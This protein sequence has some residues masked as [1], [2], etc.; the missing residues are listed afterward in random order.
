[1][2]YGFFLVLERAGLGKLL[3]HLW[4]P[5]RH[6]YTMVIVFI[7]WVFF[8][9]ETLSYS[10]QFIKA[11]FGFG[12][13]SGVEYYASS[14]LSFEVLLVVAIGAIGSMPIIPRLIKLKNSNI[15]L[16][17]VMNIFQDSYLFCV[18]VISVMYLGVYLV[19]STKVPFIYYRF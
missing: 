8:R 11:M 1:M 5:L 16:R 13:G 7:G 6:G 2:Y 18:L 3:A 17:P 4:S 19:N 15:R 9:S 12:T 14:Y 10:I